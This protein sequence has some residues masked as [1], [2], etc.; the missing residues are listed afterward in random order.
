MSTPRRSGRSKNGIRISEVAGRRRKYEVDF[1]LTIGGKPIRIRRLSPFASVGETQEWAEQ[2]REAI[3][4]RGRVVAKEAPRVDPEAPRSFAYWAERW[5][6]DAEMPA[7]SGGV[8]R[9][10]TVANKSM[11]L[12]RHL[13]PALGRRAITS[14]DEQVIEDY[15]ARKHE[16]GLASTTIALHLRHLRAVL[17]FAKKR[18]S[19]AERIHVQQPT[20]RVGSHRDRKMPKTLSEEQTAELLEALAEDVALRAFATILWRQGLRIG[21]TLALRGSDVDFTRGEINVDRTWTPHGFGPTKGGR[22]RRLPM[23]WQTRTALAELLEHKPSGEEPWRLLFEAG[24]TTR[25]PAPSWMMRLLRKHLDA[26]GILFVD[27]AGETIHLTSKLGR[28][29]LGRHWAERGLPLLGL[30]DLLGHSDLTT[31]QVYSHWSP[32][33]TAPLLQQIGAEP[34]TIERQT[35]AARLHALGVDRAILVAAGLA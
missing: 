12:A 8:N 32:R 22:P 4:R 27:D 10:A 31:T 20:V 25:P 9:P 1:A 34:G 13:A 29:S 17:R 5:L 14:I 15:V 23:H 35:I 26:Q 6:A 7:R 2:E 19:E 21:E 16:E 11:I 28:H 33:G 18:G 3:L 30:Q 24:D